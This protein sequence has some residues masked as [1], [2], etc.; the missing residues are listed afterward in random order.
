MLEEVIKLQ[1]VGEAI[2]YPDA[3]QRVEVRLDRDA[4][5]RLLSGLLEWER[6]QQKPK[7]KVQEG[8]QDVLNRIHAADRSPVFLIDA[9]LSDRE[10]PGDPFE[11]LNHLVPEA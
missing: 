7:L 10:R 5:D 8:I 2:R 9:P 3:P 1:D 6:R 4:L 11:A